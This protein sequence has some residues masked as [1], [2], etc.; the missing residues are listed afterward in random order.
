[1]NGVEP[2]EQLLDLTAHGE[3]LGDP[4][5]TGRPHA[6][7]PFGILEQAAERRRQLLY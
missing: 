3:A 6:C 4:P 5:S 1:M 7:S 2:P